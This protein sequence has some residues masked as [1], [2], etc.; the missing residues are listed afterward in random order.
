MPDFARDVLRLAIWLVLL[1]A[2]FVPQ[3]RLFTHRPAKL[4]RAQTG[5]DLAWYF[6]NSLLPALI[7]ALP[8][9][10]LAR[11]LQGIDP[12]GFYSAVAA[13][14]IWLKLFAA[15]LVND[16]GAY[17]VHRWQHASPF[18]WRF[19]AIHHSAEHVDWLT[20]TRAHPI[21]MVLVRLG[22]LV[23]DLPARPRLGDGR[24]ARSGDPV[25]FD[26]GTV[27]SFAIHANVR[28]RFGPLEWLVA[29][30]AFH[31][32][33]HTNCEKRDRNFSAVF[34]LLDRVFGTAYLPQHLP[35]VYGIDGHVAP[36]FTGQLIDPLLGPVRPK[37]QPA[38]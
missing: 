17:W 8:L 30:P 24:R 1:A 32:W 16:I 5:V 23:P 37:A 7:V 19:H 25:G 38:E 6:V 35:S 11:A 27:W 26:R 9:G 34:P 33:H 3:E 36:R 13:W 4:W 2:I 21:D 10:L 31:H 29:T 18:L 14:P 20:N 22:G 12:L 15:F 28:W